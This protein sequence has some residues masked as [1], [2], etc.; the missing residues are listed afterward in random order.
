MGSLAVRPGDSLT[1][2]RLALLV[3]FIRFVSSTDAIQVTRILTLALVGL[4][5]LNIPTF[6]VDASSR[7]ISSA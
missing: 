2:P 7:I 3:G 5:P 1:I 4:P 6:A